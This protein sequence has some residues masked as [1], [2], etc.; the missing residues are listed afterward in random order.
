MDFINEK[1]I[2][3]LIDN[4]KLNNISLQKEIIQ[5]SKEAKGLSLKESAALLNINDKE[6]LNELFHTAKEVKEKI[7]GNRLV[8]FAPLYLTNLCVNNC[9]YCA[10]RKDNKELKRKTLSLEE[11]KEE[12]EFLVGQGHKRLLLVCGEHPKKASMEFIGESIKTI[13][14]VKIKN[15]NIRRL[16][17]NTAP[18]S[19]ENFKI[20]KSFGIGTYQC[21]QETYHYE[22][23]LKMHPEG[24]KRDY[25]WRLFAM[26]R[27]LQAG[28]DDVGIGALFGLTDWKFETL[29]LLS[30]AF[31][32]DQR[33]GIGPHTISVPR[34]EPA[35]NAPVSQ[36][37]PFAVDDLSFKK[38]VAVLRLAV[39][40]TGIILSTRERAELR[41]ELFHVGVSQ[42]SAGSRTSPG[43]YKES[44]ESV[45]EYQMEQFQLGDHRSLDEVVRDCC[46]L[47][48]MP[49][50]CTACYRSNRTG[51]RFMELAKSGNIGKICVP[52]A[53]STFNEYILDF[54]SDETKIVAEDFTKKELEK[55][56]GPTKVKTEKML[57][58][59]NQGKRDIFF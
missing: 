24:P 59:I 45:E 25:S 34:L 2:F 20:L 50:F 10:F 5:K 58:K 43:A 57:Q 33:F 52:N 19:I 37:P 46:E 47:G 39:P 23:Y 22:T 38:I 11:I 48:F 30:H 9:L 44:K 21:F 56:D 31:N 32:L 14:E 16:N 42:I 41:R 15:G 4:E 1:D 27:A 53:I 12:T 35:F 6:T 3:D 49:S 54:A 55:L 36:K 29:A 40:Y 13:Y 51:D 8:L 28:I 26:D 7:Y 18:L 17:V